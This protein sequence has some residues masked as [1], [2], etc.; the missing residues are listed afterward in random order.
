MQLKHYHIMHVHD[1]EIYPM[2][3]SRNGGAKP[4]NMEVSRESMSVAE[5]SGSTI[6]RPA[7]KQ[8]I[9]FCSTT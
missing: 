9:F 3:N 5:N 8:S 6:D 2:D 1:V 7:P 4:R